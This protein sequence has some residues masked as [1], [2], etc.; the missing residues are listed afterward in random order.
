[1]Q[2]WE[3][4]FVTAEYEKD[5]WRPKYV[6]GQELRDWKKGPFIHDYSNQLG[7][8]GWEIVSFGYTATA[9]QFGRTAATW[10]RL[11]FKRSKS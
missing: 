2:K 9:N 1:M 4:L 11:V 6:N 7:E 10:Y 3:Y 8:Q 5:Q